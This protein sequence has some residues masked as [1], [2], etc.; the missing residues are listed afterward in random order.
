[1]LDRQLTP[2]AVEVD[3]LTEQKVAEYGP[4]AAAWG[5]PGASQANDAK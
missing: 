2:I 3:Q 1:L 5:R 4:I